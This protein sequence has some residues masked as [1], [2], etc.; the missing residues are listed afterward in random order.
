MTFDIRDSRGGNPC[1]GCP[2]R[3]P[4]CADHCTKPEYLKYRAEQARI[5][6]ARDAYR[7]PAWVSPEMDGGKY[8]KHKKYKL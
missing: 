5:K 7:P 6:A 2:D 1:H 4:G 3:Y 8:R